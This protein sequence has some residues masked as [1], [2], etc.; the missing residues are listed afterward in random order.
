MWQ[1]VSRH[2]EFKYR[3]VSWV[4]WVAHSRGLIPAEHLGMMNSKARKSFGGVGEALE[5]DGSLPVPKIQNF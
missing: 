2:D 1:S 3:K 4:G 5:F